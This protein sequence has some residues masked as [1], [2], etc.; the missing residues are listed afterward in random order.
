[1]MYSFGEGI[2]V[3]LHMH[4]GDVVGNNGHNLTGTPRPLQQLLSEEDDRDLYLIADN[5]KE[6]VQVLEVVGVDEDRDL[7]VEFRTWVV[8]G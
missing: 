6:Y 3:T 2:V 5:V 7:G 8:E 4:T 1:M